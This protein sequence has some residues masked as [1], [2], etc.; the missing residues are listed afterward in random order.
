MIL[1]FDELRRYINLWK[2]NREKIVFTNGCFDLLHKGHLDLLRSAKKFGD[3]LIIG[4]NSDESIKRIKGEKRPYQ[5][6]NIRATSLLETTLASAITIFNQDTPIKVIKKINPDILVKG[7]DYETSN[8]VGADF[9]IR[10]GGKVKIIELTP[11]Y[12]T[13]KLIK[14]IDNEF[15]D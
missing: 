5:T 15:L 7:S 8:V 14:K 6:Q 4:L 1:K 3:R 13:T 12:S 9:V 10:N 11:G 2:S